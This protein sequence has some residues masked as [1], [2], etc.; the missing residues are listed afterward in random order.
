MEQLDSLRWKLTVATIL[1]TSIGCTPKKSQA[2]KSNSSAATTT[3]EASVP[4]VLAVSTGVNGEATAEV[5]INAFPAGTKVTFEE[6]DTPAQFSAAADSSP[7]DSGAIRVTAT[8]KGEVVEKATAPFTISIP[9]NI[10]TTLKLADSDTKDI[11]AFLLTASGSTYVLRKT[12]FISLDSEKKIGKFRTIYLGT[13]QLTLCGTEEIP[14]FTEAIEDG[15]TGTDNEVEAAQSRADTDFVCPEGTKSFFS[16]YAA[17]TECQSYLDQTVSCNCVAIE[18][19]T[20]NECDS[21]IQTNTEAAVCIDK[22]QGVSAE[23][24]DAWKTDC[25]ERTSANVKAF[26]E[27]CG[28]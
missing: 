18:N 6:A 15:V 1:L 22:D 8:N 12:D 25:T 28:L 7:P 17:V 27:I 5:P 11:C 16:D 23:I 10:E 21:K 4:S 24:I 20:Q 19:L 14:A 2:V 9:Q 3:I 13:Y 26:G